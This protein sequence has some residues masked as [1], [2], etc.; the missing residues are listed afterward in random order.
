MLLTYLIKTY[1]KFN[2]IKLYKLEVFKYC[3]VNYLDGCGFSVDTIVGQ[4]AI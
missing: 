1:N 3:T 4:L 2:L